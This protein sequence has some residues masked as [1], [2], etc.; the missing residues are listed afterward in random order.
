MM[1]V[2]GRITR[3]L[4]N[5]RPIWPLSTYGP[6]KYQPTL[7]TGLDMS[8]EEL[9]VKAAEAARAGTTQEYVRPIS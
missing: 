3:D 8:P 9:R 4:E 6:A 2:N 1:M 7:M 5:E